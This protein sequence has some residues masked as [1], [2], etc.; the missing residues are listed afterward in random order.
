MRAPSRGR[1]TAPARRGRILQITRGSAGLSRSLSVVGPLPAA[2]DPNPGRNWRRSSSK[3]T[4][5][6]PEDRAR[7]WHGP[8]DVSFGLRFSTFD[9]R[10]DRDQKCDD[11]SKSVEAERADRRGG[12]HGTGEEAEKRRQHRSKRLD[13]RNPQGRLPVVQRGSQPGKDVATCVRLPVM[14]VVGELAESVRRLNAPQGGSS[15]SV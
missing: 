4:S 7:P 2:S 13:V 6:G 15:P 5:Y 1:W 14:I 9:D 8:F 10:G 3:N 11:R 12:D